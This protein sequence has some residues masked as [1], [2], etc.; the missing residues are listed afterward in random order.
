MNP[1][2][3]H[4]DGGP[5]HTAGRGRAA[6][7]LVAG[8]APLLAISGAT[9]W[10]L[11]L[12]FSYLI[13]VVGLYALI[14]IMILRHLPATLPG[15][16]LGAA[17]R[18]TV[19]RAMLILSVAAL[20]PHPQTLNDTGHWWIIAVATTAMVLDGVDGRVAR[21]TGTATP[22][23]ARF[24][25][26]LDSFLMLILAAL[27]W[28]SGRVGPWV[29]LL[30]LPRYLFVVAGWRCPWLRAPLPERVRRKAGCVLQGIALLV[31]LGPIVPTG[32]ATAVAALTLALL[33]SSFAVDVVWLF[34]RG[35]S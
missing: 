8:L 18:V 33:V 6:A 28:R 19:G 26:E 29:L 3:N 30:G 12:P 31:C 32:L 16:G 25:M 27:V 22:F 2:T 20:V 4:A 7:E 17:N 5:P 13:R 23:G 35:R 9:A 10:W 34:R 11:D 1:A 24:D 21:R 14:A 15:R